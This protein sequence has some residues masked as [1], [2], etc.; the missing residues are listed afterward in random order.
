MIFHQV[1]T[2]Q[3]TTCQL[4]QVYGHDAQFI[5]A[6]GRNITDLKVDVLAYFAALVKDDDVYAVTCG[7]ESRMTVFLVKVKGPRV[8]T[9]NDGATS[10]G[11]YIFPQVY[12]NFKT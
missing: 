4:S 11:F 6:H 8:T 5:D 9:V 1:T 3:P 7:N 12:L 10:D 2:N